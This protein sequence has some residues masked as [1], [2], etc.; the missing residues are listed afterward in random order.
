MADDDAPVGVMSAVLAPG[1]V[2][3]G[4][5]LLGAHT[6][7]RWDQLDGW[8][9]MP[10]LDSGDV[11]R[12]SRHGAW[13]GTDLAQPRVITLAGKLLCR[14]SEVPALVGA[15]RSATR[16]G[17]TAD[18][19]PLTVNAWGEELIA[20]VRPTQRI[21]PLAKGA[22]L[23]MIPYTL[24]WTAPDPRRYSPTEQDRTIDAPIR[25]VDGLDY[26]LDY[27]LDYGAPITGGSGT[28][29]NAGDTGTHPSVVITGPCDRP[30]IRNAATGYAMEFALTLDAAETLVIDCG[31][32]TV[33]LSGSA[34]R[35]YTRTPTSVP[36]ELWTLAPGRNQIQFRPLWSGAGAAV[37]I[38]WR[39]AYM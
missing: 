23:G 15:L 11:A 33:L 27:P 9:D 17:D 22:R 35:L 21:M 32:G 6:P 8:E 20:Y 1:Q 34:D 25:P 5:L 30:M 18:L 10:P 38:R 14:R 36:A 4:G 28:L 19:H 16:V 12:P 26:P 37:T 29:T 13:G 24:Q 39:D 2:S 31:A 3:W 7:W